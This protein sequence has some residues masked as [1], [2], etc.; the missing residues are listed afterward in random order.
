[1]RATRYLDQCLKELE[2]NMEYDSD[3]QLVTLVRI[4]HLMERL[5]RLNDDGEPTEEIFAIPTLPT[6]REVVLSACQV[7]LERIKE[8]MPAGLKSNSKSTP[9]SAV[10]SRYRL[11]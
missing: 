1:M 5:S 2:A 4:Q 3:A 11:D 6:L 9:R 10:T 7:E 8:N